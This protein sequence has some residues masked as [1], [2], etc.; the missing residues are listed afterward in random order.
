L[1]VV[2]ATALT[3]VMVAGVTVGFGRMW[4][5]AVEIVRVGNDH[6]AYRGLRLAWTQHGGQLFV[7]GIVLFW[8]ISLA[9]YWIVQARHPRP[10]ISRYA[11]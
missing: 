1:A 8:M 6:P 7:L 10:K 5:G 4:E 2:V 3:S 11:D 9:H